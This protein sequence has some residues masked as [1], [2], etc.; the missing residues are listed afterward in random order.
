METVNRQGQIVRRLPSEFTV[1]YRTVTGKEDEWFLAAELY[2]QPGDELQAISRI[3]ELLKRRSDTQP[4]G[5]PSCGSVFRNPEGKFAAEL[6]EASKL[7]GMRVGDAEVSTK[8]A[9]FII[10]VGSASAHD[11]E[12]LIEIVLQKVWHDHAV[13]LYPEV[14]FIGIKK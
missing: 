14:K 6:I 8:H 1:G 7:K 4:I 13:Q 5:L 2:F 11:V 10:N 12:T 9:N 3:K